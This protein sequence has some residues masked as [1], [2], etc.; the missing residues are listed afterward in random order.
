M[1]AKVGVVMFSRIRFK[2]LVGMANSVD[3]DLGLYC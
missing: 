3:L 1:F 2:I